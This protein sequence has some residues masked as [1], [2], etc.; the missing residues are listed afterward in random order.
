MAYYEGLAQILRDDLA[1][2]RVIEK[3]MFGGLCFMLE[4]NMLCGI[5]KNGAMFRVGPD[6]YVI[7]LSLPGADQ[8][9]FTGR[10]MKGFVD[11]EPDTFT[12]DTRRA[13]FLALAL[14]FVKSLPPK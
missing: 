5:H 4:G 13:P 9:R 1:D 3:K 6:H 2:E 7:A 14:S 12:D 10:P 8:M 11:C